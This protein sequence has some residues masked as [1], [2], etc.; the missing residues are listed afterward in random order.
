MST[1]ANQG[2]HQLWTLAQRIPL[3]HPP[4]IC[5]RRSSPYHAFNVEIF[6]EHASVLLKCSISSSNLCCD[7]RRRHLARGVGRLCARWRGCVPRHLGGQVSRRL[8][9]ACSIHAQCV[10][11]RATDLGQQLDERDPGG[12]RSSAFRAALRRCGYPRNVQS[13][14]MP[15]GFVRSDHVGE[16]G[17][18]ERPA[19]LRQPQQLLLKCSSYTQTQAAA[20]IRYKL[21]PTS[22]LRI[23]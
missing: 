9:H 3:P 18:V 15:S 14:A 4:R 5:R 21:S 7:D 17:V 13:H 22:H 19:R 6:L 23:P 1:P 8:R 11:Q 2:I 12:K 16:A 10:R 20:D